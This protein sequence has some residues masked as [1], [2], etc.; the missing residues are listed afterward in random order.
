MKTKQEVKFINKAFTGQ[1]VFYEGQK[2][3][4]FDALVTIPAGTEVSHN[5]A[6]GMD[7]NYHF[8]CDFSCIEYHF[9]HDL[10]YHGANVPKEFIEY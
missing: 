6:Y 4:R 9:H 5:T 2:L 3:E 7:E 1:F 8:V 10:T